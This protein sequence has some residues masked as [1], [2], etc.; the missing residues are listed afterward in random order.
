MGNFLAQVFGGG[1]VTAPNLPTYD[2]STASTQFQNQNF[3]AAENTANQMTS[4]M[5][6][7]N[8]N[9]ALTGLGT[10]DPNAVAG[11][12][13][14]QNLGNTLMSG[15]GSALPAW[16][17]Q[18]MNNAQMTGSESAIGRG[19]GAFSSNGQSGVNEYVGNNAMNL[20][21]MGAGLANN[22]SS[23]A[24]GMVEQN[25]YRADPMAGLLSAS[26]FMQAGMFNTQIQDQQAEDNTEVANYNANNSPLGNMTRTALQMLASL[27]GSKMGDSA[28]GNSFSTSGNN[29]D[30]P[31]QG[32]SSGGSSGGSGGGGM[33]LSDA[34]SSIFA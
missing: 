7:G 20:V 25:M 15:S 3:G 2:P 19:V 12:D 5:S 26:Q 10:I 29:Q 22:A 16:A 13:E 8:L 27:V 1:S 34:F 32:S 24:N 11:I 9:T 17:K 28:L 23:Q 21:N 4:S 33:D 30:G 14:E 31:Q 18:Y 6:A